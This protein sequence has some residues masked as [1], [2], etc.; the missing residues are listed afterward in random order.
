VY[1][2]EHGGQAGEDKAEDAFIEFPLSFEF[3][4]TTLLNYGI[5]L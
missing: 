3:T 4:A 1:R 5:A 2:Q